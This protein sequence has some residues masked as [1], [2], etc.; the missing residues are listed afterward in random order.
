MKR[1]L[2][3]LPLA[4]AWLMLCAFF[5][6]WIFT[7]FLTDTSADKKLVIYVDA[8]I[9][10]PTRLSARM[11]EIWNERGKERYPK[12]RMLQAREFTYSMMGQSPFQDGDALVLA[13]S[14]LEEYKDLLP[15]DLIP[16]SAARPFAD[17]I[18]YGE[19]QQYFVCVNPKSVHQ[20]DG[21]AQAA[22]E[23]LFLP[24]Q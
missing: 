17:L 1:F 10:D 15:E 23:W 9:S 3:A 18:S 16:L 7:S 24:A 5:W 2:R 8:V 14:S 11:E 20:Q 19:D 6:G 21:A 22:L 12:I 13:A 4:L